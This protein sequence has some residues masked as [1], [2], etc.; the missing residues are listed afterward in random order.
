MEPVLITIIT[1]YIPETME[2]M[3]K[4]RWK[5]VILAWVKN[6]AALR[7]PTKLKQVSTSTKPQNIQKQFKKH[8]AFA[9]LEAST[10]L[11]NETL[12]ELASSL[13]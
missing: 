13:V 7:R 1:T 2:L 11:R 10:M 5:Q 6:L 12:C 8:A 4:N 3:L 9:P